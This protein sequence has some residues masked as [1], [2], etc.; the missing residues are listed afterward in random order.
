VWGSC[1]GSQEGTR[2]YTCGLWLALHSLA[3]HAAP[4]DSGGAFFMASLRCTEKAPEQH[5][6]VSSTALQASCLPHTLRLWCAG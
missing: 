6:C 2:G 4:E 1:K 5:V 3:A